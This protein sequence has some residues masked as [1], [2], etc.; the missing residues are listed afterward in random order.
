MAVIKLASECV[1][2]KAQKIRLKA[3]VGAPE[4]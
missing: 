4:F 1:E 2:R 3:Q